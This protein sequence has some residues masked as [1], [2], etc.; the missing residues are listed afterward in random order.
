LQAQEQGRRPLGD[1]ADLRAENE[2]LRGRLKAAEREAR[3]FSEQAADAERRA[4]FAQEV[5]LEERRQYER[6]RVNLEKLIKALGGNI[7]PPA[8]PPPPPEPPRP[9]SRRP[10]PAPP[11]V[12]PTNGNATLPAD[13]GEY[14]E[15]EQEEPLVEDRPSALTRLIGR[16]QRPGGAPRKCSVCGRRISTFDV[17][18]LESEGWVV[19]GRVAVCGTCTADGWELEKEA[20]L[21]FRRA[22]QKDAQA[23]E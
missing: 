5:L 6:E 4:Q 9:E 22:S 15:V 12:A 20:L 11:E 17:D 14:L 8:A 23:A 10:E 3:Q 13:D 7:E 2:S 1:R 21:P 19:T 16:R 18:E